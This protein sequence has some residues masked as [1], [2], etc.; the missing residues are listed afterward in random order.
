[1]R[2]RELDRLLDRGIAGSRTRSCACS[3]MNVRL[4]LTLVGHWVVG[5]SWFGGQ[6]VVM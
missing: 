3:V 6:L 2:R 4:G 1:M 5:K